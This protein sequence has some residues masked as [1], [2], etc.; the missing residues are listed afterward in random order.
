MRYILTHKRT[1]FNKQFP[2]T[3]VPIRPY[4]IY[5]YM[6]ITKFQFEMYMGIVYYIDFP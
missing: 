1:K 2:F 5:R 6:L 4:I 3:R